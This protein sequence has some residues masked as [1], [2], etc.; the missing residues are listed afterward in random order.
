MDVASK[1]LALSQL[2]LVT[3]AAALVVLL[4]TNEAS[5]WGP[6]GHCVVARLAQDRLTGV[7][8]SRVAALLA[9]DGSTDMASVASWADRPDVK[10]APGRPLHT[11]RM[12]LVSSGYDEARD[13]PSEKPC[14]IKAI[15]NAEN[16]LTDPGATLN[17]QIVAI[18]D[19]IHF[20]GDIHQPLH[21]SKI[22]G[23]QQVVMD[24]KTSTLHEVWDIGIIAHQERTCRQ[25]VTLIENS[26]D[27][28]PID[29]KTPE[30][31]AVE[32]RDIAIREI[33]SETEPASKTAPATILADDYAL[34]HWP[35]VESRLKQAGVRLAGVL[36]SIFR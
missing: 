30:D 19:L 23:L 12:A 36:N 8:A 35:T 25:L 7:A 13:C 27:P 29:Q 2:R 3:T 9:A 17:Q 24:G 14:V 4:A 34:R 10:L 31:W 22:V 5:A 16:T 21:T 1:E 33:F 26:P 11:V 15:Q 18:K 28:A 6:K 32:G 20:V